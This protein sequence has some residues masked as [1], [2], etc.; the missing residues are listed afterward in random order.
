MSDVSIMSSSY[1]GLTKKQLID[2]IDK[3]FPD[4]QYA[5]IAVL[6][7]AVARSKKDNSVKIVNQSITLADH[8]EV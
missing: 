6:T 8:L 5:E 7:T 3:T 2:A 1:R 4:D